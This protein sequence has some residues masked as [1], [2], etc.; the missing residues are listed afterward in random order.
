MMTGELVLKLMLSIYTLLQAERSWQLPTRSYKRGR[1]GL[2]L[3][4]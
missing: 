3:R 2:K 4:F 1:L